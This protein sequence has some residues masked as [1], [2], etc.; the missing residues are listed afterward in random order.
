MVNVPPTS[1]ATTCCQ[2]Q[3]ACASTEECDCVCD[4]GAAEKLT[5]T[6][7]SED[8]IQREAAIEAYLVEASERSL[9]DMTDTLWRLSRR[10]YN[11][12]S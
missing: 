3:C 9:A 6:C 5:R 12:L 8:P 10:W 4:C 2:G 11:T 1:H 7:A